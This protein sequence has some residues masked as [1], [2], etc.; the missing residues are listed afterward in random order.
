MGGNRQV[1]Y[2]EE[3]SIIYEAIPPSKMWNFT[4]FHI[5]G[6]SHSDFLQGRVVSMNKETVTLCG[7]T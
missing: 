1:S 3:F 2:L 7:E 5:N 4:I 6:A